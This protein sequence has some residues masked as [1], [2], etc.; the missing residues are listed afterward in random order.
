MRVVSLGSGSSG[1]ALLV[2]AGPQGR[3]RL[4]VDAGLNA[5]T[6]TSRLQS[7]G[8]SPAQLQAILVT[9]EHSDHVQGISTLIRRCS[10]H[11]I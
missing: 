4:L 8:V 5:R 1:N 6:I 10:T 9:H 7:V 11:R 3:T 2:E